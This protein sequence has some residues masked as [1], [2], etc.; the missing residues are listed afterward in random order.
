MGAGEPLACGLG[1]RASWNGK[2]R[3]R[4][5]GWDLTRSGTLARQIFKFLLS[6]VPIFIF[7]YVF[8]WFIG[9]VPPDSGQVLIKKNQLETG[10]TATF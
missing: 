2:W 4:G 9:L 6:F 5:H 3:V 7:F 1:A 10:A 8:S